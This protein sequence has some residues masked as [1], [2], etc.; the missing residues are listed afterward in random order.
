[1][2]TVKWLLPHI[3]IAMSFVLVLLVILNEYNP[4]MGLLSNDVSKV[5]YLIYAAIC[6]WTSVE[7]VKKDE[8]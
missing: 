3:S 8:I 5:F 4:A 2:K 1:M 7:K 6:V